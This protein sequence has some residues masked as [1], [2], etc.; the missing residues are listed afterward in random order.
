VILVANL[1]F[2]VVA[3]ASIIISFCAVFHFQEDHSVFQL[4]SWIELC[5]S[6]AFQ[7]YICVSTLHFN[8]WFCSSSVS[9]DRV[10]EIVFCNNLV[11][12]SFSCVRR[13]KTFIVTWN[14][15]LFFFR[16]HFFCAFLVCYFWDCFGFRRINRGGVGFACKINLPFF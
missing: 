11:W 14:L 16:M 13:G 4:Q 12:V 10:L 9:C 8:G 3:V 6:F 15:L 1:Y 5:L 2:C 7:V